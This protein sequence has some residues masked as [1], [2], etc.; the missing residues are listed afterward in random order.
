MIHSLIS[1]F[2]I[3][4]K[5]LNKGIY[6]VVLLVLF[7][8]AINDS[9]TF[10]QNISSDLSL[11]SAAHQSEEHD[12][13]HKKKVK[14]IQA[15]NPLYWMYQG[16]IGFYQRHVSPQLATGCIYETSCSRFSRKLIGE[17]GLVKGFFLSCDRISRCNRVTH[18]ETSR[19]RFTPEGKIKEDVSHFSFRQ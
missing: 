3:T 5:P 15:I 17:Y 10:A 14:V 16:S 11:I 2:Q 8:Y 4:L 7:I 6:R 18:S 9:N 1:K 12:H 19:L 13:K